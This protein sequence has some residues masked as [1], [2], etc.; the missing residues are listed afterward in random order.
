MSHK[1]DGAMPSALRP[2]D[3]AASNSVQSRAGAERGQPVSATASADQMRLTGDADGL[4]ALERQLGDG[5]ASIDIA[6]STAFARPC[7]RQLPHRCAAIADRMI[8]STSSSASKQPR[9]DPPL[10]ALERALNGRAPRA[11]RP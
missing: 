5:P 9:I 11:A 3:A 6:R 1:I 7:R 8:A 4:Q 2:V 10:E